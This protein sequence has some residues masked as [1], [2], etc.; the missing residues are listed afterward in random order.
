[1]AI[2]AGTCASLRLFGDDLDPDDISRQL[3]AV[4][5]DAQRKGELIGPRRNTVARTGGWKLSTEREQ[6]DQLD[7]QVSALLAATTADQN[8]WDHLTRRFSADVFCGVWL[9]EPGEG[10]DLEP[11][12]LAELGRRGLRLE[13][14]IYYPDEAHPVTK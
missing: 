12:T 6:G 10:L 1:M 4:P 13:L 11:A 9:D 2:V 5:S 14:D 3:R 8:V 7:R